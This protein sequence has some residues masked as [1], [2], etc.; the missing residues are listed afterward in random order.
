ML[1]KENITR[2]I[3]VYKYMYRGLG[4]VGIVPVILLYLVI[5]VFQFIGYLNER[6]TD[7]LIS[8]IIIDMQVFQPLISCF[9]IMTV[10][11]YFTEHDSEE[12][13]RFLFGKHVKLVCF[14]VFVYYIVLIPEAIVYAILFGSEM[15]ICEIRVFIDVLFLSAVG[16]YVSEYINSIGISVFFYV[17]YSGL[18]YFEVI[19]NKNYSFFSWNN[20]NIKNM[21]IES[22]P[23]LISGIIIYFFQLWKSDRLAS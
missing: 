14:S 1:Y 13:I 18:C 23:Y 21:F 8:R 6:R 10:V 22:L 16:L 9:F 20:S 11:Y 15:I 17:F 4:V 12:S 7:I 2:L 5:P 19:L 3:R